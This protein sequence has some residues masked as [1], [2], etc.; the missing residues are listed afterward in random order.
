LQVELKPHTAGSELLELRV[1]DDAKSK[2]ANVIFQA[3]QDRR[4][5]HIL[6]IRD[7]NTLNLDFR[8][9]RLMTLVQLFLIHRYKSVVIHY[10]TPTD[11]NQRQTE[12]MK[13]LGIFD[14][15]HTEIGDMIVASVN[16]ERVRELLQ[17]EGVELEQLICKS[18][19]YA[20]T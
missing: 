13:D 10:V 20:G 11:D 6:S 8:R 17:P 15:V 12:R 19:S 3:I 4:E 14:E 1:L 7:Q 9:K 2:I 16:S 5:R 18:G